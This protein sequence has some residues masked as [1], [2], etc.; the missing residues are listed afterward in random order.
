MILMLAPGPN[1]TFSARPSGSIYISDDDRLIRVLNNSQVDVDSLVES[2]VSTLLPFGPWGS[3]GFVTLAD[4]YAYDNDPDT[5]MTEYTVT[6]IFGDPVSTN[7]GTWTKTGN[8][9]GTGNWTQVSQLTL[10]RLAAEI[11]AVT[12]ASHYAA[13][14]P[15][16]LATTS[17]ITLSG[18][19]TIDGTLTSNTDVVVWNQADRTKNGVY[20]SNAGAWTRRSDANTA[21]ELGGMLVGVKNGVAYSGAVFLL[22]LPP[23]SIVVGTTNL[24]FILTRYG[25]EA[26]TSSIIGALTFSDLANVVT[27]NGAVSDGQQAFC[28]Y[29]ASTLDDSGGRFAFNSNADPAFANGVTSIRPL[30]RVAGAFNGLWIRKDA[31][32]VNFNSFL[33]PVADISTNMSWL[34][35]VDSFTGYR[36]GVSVGETVT[37][38]NGV[39][40]FTYT[41]VNPVVA[42]PTTVLAAGEVWVGANTSEALTNL[43]AAMTN[44]GVAGTQYG[45]G[46]PHC[47]AFVTVSIDFNSL[48]LVAVPTGNVGYTASTTASRLH[49]PQILSFTRTDYG[50]S[51][52]RACL[53]SDTFAGGTTTIVVPY[54]AWPI[55][56]SVSDPNCVSLRFDGIMIGMASG[57]NIVRGS[58]TGVATESLAPWTILFRRAIQ[59]WTDETPGVVFSNITGLGSGYVDVASCFVGVQYAG[60]VGASVSNNGSAW[61]R[62]T[63]GSMKAN[64]NDVHIWA[65]HHSNSYSNQMTHEFTRD[66]TNTLTNY[67]KH[68]SVV[69][70]QSDNGHAINGHVFINPD[71]ERGN[72][73]AGKISMFHG[74]SN[75]VQCTVTCVGTALT[76][77]AIDWAPGG[78]I[79]AGL[80][81]Q[82]D[83]IITPGTQIVSGPGGG[84]VGSYVIDTAHTIASPTVI[85]MCDPDTS[86]AQNIRM[87]GGRIEVG[88]GYL[89]TGLGIAASSFQLGYDNQAAQ[90]VNSTLISG[91]T[92]YDSLAMAA[93]ND[94]ESDKNV[95][96]KQQMYIGAELTQEQMVM[97][98]PWGGGT[99]ALPHPPDGKICS[100]DATTGVVEFQNYTTTGSL[101]PGSFVMTN[102]G[103]STGWLFDF[104]QCIADYKRIMDLEW[105]TTVTGGRFIMKI[106]HPD[107]TLWDNDK[108]AQWGLV[109]NA[110][111]KQYRSSG[112]LTNSNGLKRVSLPLCFVFIGVAKGSANAKGSAFRVFL[113]E[114]SKIKKANSPTRYKALQKVG[115]TLN[116][117][118]LPDRTPVLYGTP[119]QPA[120]KAITGITA[121]TPPVVTANAHG[122]ANDDTAVIKNVVGMT[123][124]NS[125]TITVKNVT[126][127]T[128][129]AYDVFG[130]PL[131]GLTYSAYVSGGTA[132]NV[133]YADGLRAHTVAGTGAIGYEYINGVWV[134]NGI[135]PSVSADKG[136]N[137]VTLQFGTNE[138]TSQWKTALTAQRTVTLATQ[139]AIAGAEL[140]ILRTATATGN[141]KLV[142]G[143]VCNLMAGQGCTVSYDGSAWLLK[144][145][146]S[147]SPPLEGVATYDPPSLAA[148]ASSSPTT[149][150]V[151]GAALG[152]YPTVSFSLDCQ[153]VIPR[154]WVSAANTV[155]VIFTNLTG[156]TIDL[157][158]GQLRATT[159]KP[160]T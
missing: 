47:E 18:E 43:K 63:Y 9:S 134:L 48:R 85:T 96:R 1:M 158:S 37:F 122:Y 81:L 139:D 125:M 101:T 136:D 70:M 17:N 107:G 8:G 95:P 54:G 4:M 154:A 127:N 150:T 55:W 77:S 21:D 82:L 153:G 159:T 58:M 91:D 35:Y 62:V 130:N 65:S 3:R 146:W 103:I 92:P 137:S 118:I 23:S 128:F 89:L 97:C 12:T 94:I 40:T 61:A 44:T 6:S 16:S 151:T 74:S 68:T 138:V 121:A 93:Q 160:T 22:P 109:W 87:Y 10:E 25:T 14:G 144:S 5:T 111:T 72:V 147:L 112:D 119:V 117:P 133:D 113:P 131:P 110:A 140:T 142:V 75:I 124:I 60:A 7:N 78:G 98:N 31:N 59:D 19:Q 56:T 86:V 90:N 49:G 41:F 64:A 143:S 129:E 141:F 80:R 29:G 34:L 39:T 149:V 157:A 71:C 84:G 66:S 116:L 115:S 51:L 38:N 148:G 76:V 152:D 79:V 102:S 156:G 11:T 88:V 20:T 42:P 53:W 155:S 67:A 46:T 2:G 135:R 126:T 32:E 106:F 69:W 108:N 105:V 100:V 73:G 120:T 57:T 13:N 33:D 27:L 30:D 114:G 145:F 45:V 132:Q 15:A 24:D 123:Q 99:A 50:P 26:G 83:G 52:T 36:I 28:A 104:T